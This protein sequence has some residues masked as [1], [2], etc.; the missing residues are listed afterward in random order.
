MSEKIP[1]YSPRWLSRFFELLNSLPIPFWVLALGY[2][3]I[4]AII[5]HWIAWEQGL[6]AQGQINPFL[7]V[8]PMFSLGLIIAWQ[9]M[10]QRA[11]LALNKFFIGSPKKVKEIDRI[12]SEFLSL[13]AFPATVLFILGMVT[14]YGAFLDAVTVDPQATQVWPAISIL[15]YGLFLAFSG[16]LIYRVFRQI[17]MMRRLLANI[18]A[19]IFNPQPVY[20]LSSYGAAVAIAVFLA[21]TVPSLPLSNFFVTPGAIINVYVIAVLVLVVFFIPLN[22]I[23][24]RMRSNKEYLLAELGNDLKQVQVGIHKAVSKKQFSEVDKMRGT[25]SAL[26][27]ER[28]LIQKLPT[29]PWQPETLRNLLTPFLIPVAV[30][31]VTRYLGAFLGLQ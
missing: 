8:N 23:N 18:D 4:L 20:A 16:L 26:R 2:V 27:E 25:L 29:W 21:Q 7:V 12:T 3:I 19:D 9:Y 5:R 24:K 15:G 28:E 10:D 14:G 22:Q 6:V 31:L 11:E 13:S 1:A 30:F 17:K